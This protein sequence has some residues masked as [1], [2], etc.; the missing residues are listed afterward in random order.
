MVTEC[1]VRE[2]DLCFC[3]GLWSSNLDFQ[4]WQIGD[5]SGTKKVLVGGDGRYMERM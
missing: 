2:G 5:E 4:N 3:R 1:D